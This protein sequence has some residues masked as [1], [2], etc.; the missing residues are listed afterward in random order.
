MFSRVH[1]IPVQF[2]FLHAYLQLMRKPTPPS[3]FEKSEC[4]EVQHSMQSTSSPDLMNS[5][6]PSGFF[7]SH[8]LLAAPM[9]S[10][11]FFNTSKFFAACEPDSLAASASLSTSPSRACLANSFAALVPSSSGLQHFFS[12]SPNGS[13]MLTGLFRT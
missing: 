13:T 10:M 5:S 3:S 2:A 8:I 6:Q 4:I 7:A 1:G 12:S 9:M 11:D